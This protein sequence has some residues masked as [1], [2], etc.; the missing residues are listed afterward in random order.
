MND[1]EKEE[2]LKLTGFTQGVFPIRYLGLPLPSKRWSKI[3]CHQLVVK[4]IG[5]ISTTYARQLCYEGRLQVVMVVLFSIR[6]FWGSVFILPQSIVKEVDGK[7]RDYLWGGIQEKRKAPLVAWDKLCVPKKYGGLNIKG[8]GNWN[9]A[10]FGKLL[11]KIVVN[12]ESL[13]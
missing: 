10:S 2:L 5:T 4:I 8:C 7:C 6:S 1:Q 9:V 12:K 3:E 13:W 11:W